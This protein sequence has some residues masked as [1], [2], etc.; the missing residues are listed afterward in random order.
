MRHARI[1]DRATLL[2]T[3]GS[4]ACGGRQHLGEYAYT[5]KTIG[6]TYETQPAPILYTNYDLNDNNPP[7][8]RVYSSP[9]R[10]RRDM[11]AK[12]AH[13]RLDSAATA[14]DFPAELASG[15][16]ARASNDLGARPVMDPKRADFVLEIAVQSTGL[17]LYEPQTTVLFVEAEC[18][19]RD[20]RTGRE[21]WRTS[22]QRRERLSDFLS[23]TAQRHADI[24]P[25]LTVDEIPVTEYEHMLHQLVLFAARQITED[26]RTGSKGP[27]S[28]ATVTTVAPQ[29]LNAA[30]R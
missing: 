27:S 28:V 24:G 16:L 1:R 4:L 19:L 22:V 6:I 8:E 18:T 25:V 10:L 2:L 20:A 7:F 21:I 15:V 30:Q 3:L 9:P 13:A 5:G 17:Q 29:T 14:I 12:I 26:L 11:L 23:E